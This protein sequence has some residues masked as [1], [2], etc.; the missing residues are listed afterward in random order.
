[1][2]KKLTETLS[3]S[4]PTDNI[5]EIKSD[6][7]QRL[8]P[9]SIIYF[10]IKH[11][12]DAVRGS[13]QTIAIAP[14]AIIATTGDNRWVILAVFALALSIG[15]IAI[16][17]V[18]F[19][20]FRFRI[21]GDKFLIR[22]GVFVR[23]RL[24]L[25][26][27]RIQNVGFREPIYFRPFGLIIMGL[28]SAGSSSE[29][30]SLGGVSR[31]LGQ[32]I[33][34]H[35]LEYKVREQLTISEQNPVSQLNSTDNAV[36]PVEEELLKQ[37][38]SELVRYGLSNNNI[39][40]FAGIGA[41]LLSQMKWWE[42]AILI[43][44]F[45][46][47]EAFIGTGLIALTLLIM[48]GALLTLFLIMAASVVG[49]VIV[50]YNYRL[51]YADKRFHRTRGLLERQETSLPEVKIQNI[52]IAQP[53]IAKL[54]Q[55]SHITVGQIGFKSKN[56]N[57][58]GKKF[59]IPSVQE[60]FSNALTQRLYAG[61]S[62]HRSKLNAISKKFIARHVL[63]SVLPIALIVAGFWIYPLGWLAV[64]PLFAPVVA[65]PIIM[66]RWKRYGYADDGDVGLV[67]SGFFGHQKTVF[68]FHKV[69]SVQI[70]RTPG[71]LRSGLATLR[72]MLAG[73]TAIIPYMANE[74]ANQWR[75][76][77]LYVVETTNKPWM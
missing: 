42:S 24:S 32:A 29:E 49:A 39:W 45:D 36:R 2:I 1:M 52:T 37:P 10:V 77:I 75:D 76:R 74:D 67:Q 3:A 13:I 68:P 28:E 54:L 26:F 72:I 70:T 35:I 16:S 4:A 48:T 60:D 61:T 46:S 57:N 65:T 44:T 53:L 6:K 69:Q 33:R 20:K 58:R 17:V 7:W 27:D 12:V 51:T 19:F 22:S 31:A 14:A 73:K 66:L 15:L 55:R 34:K 59:I 43:D 23:K 50:N 56:D 18:S 9:L 25:S 5:A 38:I 62:I 21:E 30:V 40:V 71:Q 11:I 47:V 8:S 64:I 41:A 63:F